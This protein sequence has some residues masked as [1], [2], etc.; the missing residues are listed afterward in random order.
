MPWSQINPG[1]LTQPERKLSALSHRETASAA[2]SDQ[3]PTQ[4]ETNETPRIGEYPGEFAD[5]ASAQE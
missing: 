3:T 5:A 4:S 1:R 2:A